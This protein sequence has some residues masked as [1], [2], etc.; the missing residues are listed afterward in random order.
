[1]NKYNNFFQLSL[2]FEL[3]LISQQF[4]KND[5]QNNNFIDSIKRNYN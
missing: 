3:S 5:N 2:K 1:M 4:I